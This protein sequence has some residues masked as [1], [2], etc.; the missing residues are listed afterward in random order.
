MVLCTNFK[1][2]QDL[3]RYVATRRPGAHVAAV[4][5]ADPD[6]CDHRG[7]DRAERCETGDLALVAAGP[8]VGEDRSQPSG[9]RGVDLLAAGLRDGPVLAFCDSYDEYIDL[10]K[11]KTIH[12]GHDELFLPVGVPPQ[13][14][15]QDIGELY[16]QDVKKIHDHL[17]SKGIKTALW[18]DMLLQSVRGVG[19]QKKKDF[20]GRRFIRVQYDRRGQVDGSSRMEDA[21]DAGMGKK[22]KEV[23]NR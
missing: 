2:K 18:G 8:E 11:P 19:L 22:M 5:L 13:C 9:Q 10:L 20:T 14:D 16:G 4:D 6:C 7:R 3:Y 12:I 15:D 23:R 17:A 1:W 21:D